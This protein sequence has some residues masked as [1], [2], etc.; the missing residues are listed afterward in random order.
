MNHQILEVPEETK[1]LHGKGFDADGRGEIVNGAAD[2]PQQSLHRVSGRAHNLEA[3]YP[4]LECQMQ[5]SEGGTSGTHN[6][7]DHTNFLRIAKIKV[8]LERP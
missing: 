1:C 2:D 4:R 6:V 5:S 7:Q 8:D 3:I